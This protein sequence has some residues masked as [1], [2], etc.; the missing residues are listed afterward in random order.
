MNAT[1]RLLPVVALL[2][3]L[4]GASACKKESKIPVLTLT[5][6]RH[7]IDVVS[8]QVVSIGIRGR[9]DNSTLARLII[10]SKRDNSFTTTIK[11]TALSGSSLAWNW[12]YLVQHA[13]QPY[14][15]LL[16]F[17]LID[18]EGAQMQD[19]RALYVTLGATI[20]TETT[21]HLFYSGASTVHLESAFD[22]EERVQVLYTVDSVR[23]DVQD[24]TAA[25]AD[26]LSRTWFSPAGGRFI[27]FNSFDYAN[28]TDVSL[29]NAFNSGLPLEQ[30][31]GIAA[32]DIII[33]RLGSQPANVSYYA[34]LRVTEV[35]DLPGS[36]DND[37]YVFNLKWAR[38]EQ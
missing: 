21:G 17:T 14:M 8:G 33:A 11:D 35:V 3:L 25:G 10:T 27:R 12:E 13:T 19:T 36:A 38:F 34:A 20:L 29:R 32:G 24:A 5:P 30:L 18:A 2:S 15:E 7:D 9:S 4:L 23:R 1:M 37:R 16:T 6:S 22:L 31:D 26:Q 28:A